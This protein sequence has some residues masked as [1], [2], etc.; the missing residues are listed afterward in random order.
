MKKLII[1]S[2]IRNYEV[3]FISSIY[4]HLKNESEESVF[5]IDKFINS[6]IKLKRKKILI[7]STEEAK[8]FSKLQTIIQKLLNFRITRETKIICVGGGVVQDISSFLSSII[9]RGL[10]WHFYP[11]TIISQCDSCIGGKTSINFKGFKNL[12]GNFYP[13][14]KIKIDINIL[15]HLKFREILSGLG[16]MSHY[17]FLSKKNYSFFFKNLHKVYNNKKLL[18]KI[19]YQSLEIKKR[20]IELDEFDTGKRLILNFGHTFGHAI[21]KTTNFKIPHG[22]AVA[23]GIQISLFL[24]NKLRLLKRS[25][26]LKMTQNIKKITKLAPISKLNLLN[27]VKNIEKDKKHNN[28]NFRFILTKGVGEMMVY[29]LPKTVDIKKMLEEYFNNYAN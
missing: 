18:K 16:E 3:E 12:I 13:P 19:I 20:Y 8:N 1:S 11:T 9:F 14:K 21:E 15:K 2:K 25:D 28:K 24:S 22:I 7:S 6:K 10:D 5:I 27:F 4:D 26:Y 23:H 17:F 29:Q